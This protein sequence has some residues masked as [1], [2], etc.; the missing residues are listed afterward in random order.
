MALGNSASHWGSLSKFIHWTIA[1]CILVAMF[2]AILNNQLLDDG[3]WQRALATELI[4]VHRSC[5]ITALFLGVVRIIWIVW[6]GRPALPTNINDVDRR[7]AVRSHKLI[8]ILA[9]VVPLTGWLTTAAFGSKFQWFYLFDVVNPIDKN[10]DI[11]PYF[12]HAHWILY[13][14]LLVLVVLHVGAALWHH[15]SQR[16]NV[17][18][19]MLPGN[20]Q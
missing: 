2:T 16:D 15:Y 19:R 7:Y 10:R 12:Y 9:I 18:K 1:I 17:L 5:G 14:M 20:K 11:V 3:G 8:Y 13:H 6:Q 4:N